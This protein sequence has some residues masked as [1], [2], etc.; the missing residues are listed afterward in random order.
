MQ[1]AHDR[2]IEVYLF[3]WNI[4]TYGADGKYGITPAQ[5]NPATIDYFRKSVREM[6]LAYPLLAGFGITAGENMPDNR[7]DEFSREQWLWRTYG[8]GIRDAARLQ[9][10]RNIRLI[11]RYHQTNQS[12]ILAAF[13]DYPI[14]VGG[15][16]GSVQVASQEIDNGVFAAFAPFDDPQVAIVI[17]AEK[18][19]TGGSLGGIARGFFDACFGLNKPETDIFS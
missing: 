1:Y 7:K 10:G 3:T 9:P 4:F 17:V 18:A 8:E 15:K 16:T 5:T 13:K 14:Q 19:G 6:V 2:G 12:E 11:H